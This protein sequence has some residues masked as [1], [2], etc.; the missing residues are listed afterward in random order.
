MTSSF[1]TDYDTEANTFQDLQDLILLTLTNSINASATSITVDNSALAALLKMGTPITF[2]GD[3]GAGHFEVAQVAGPASGANIPITRAAE[4]T[5]AI[6][7]PAG[8][9]VT[10]EPT[11]GTY[12][13]LKEV[14]LGR[15]E[16]S[17]AGGSRHAG[18]ISRAG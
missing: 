11:A 9:I 8:T 13:I 14:I 15:T 6:S 18:W 12:N 3:D 17:G 16:I 5:T 1:P 4:G 2:G 7:H 10:Q